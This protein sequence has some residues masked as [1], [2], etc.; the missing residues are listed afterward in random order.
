MIKFVSTLQQ[1]MVFFWYLF[2]R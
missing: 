2:H 1:V